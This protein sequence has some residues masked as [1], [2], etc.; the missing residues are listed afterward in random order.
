M[1]TLAAIRDKNTLP[2]RQEERLLPLMACSLVA[3]Q[4]RFQ[5][6]VTSGF[7]MG[8]AVWG[9]G[10]DSRGTNFRLGPKADDAYGSFAS[11]IPDIAFFR[12][13]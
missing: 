5:P 7:A 11:P 1:L 12:N 10:H 3:I 13:A 4:H 9:H 2:R 8:M 6:R